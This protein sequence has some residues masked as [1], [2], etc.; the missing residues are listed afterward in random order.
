MGRDKITRREMLQI[1]GIAVAVGGV[2][3][4]LSSASTKN[5]VVRGRSKEE[6]PFRISLNTATI[7]GYELPVEQQI[8][9]CAK[10]GFDGIELWISD[11]KNYIKQGGTPEALSRQ[12]KQQGLLLENMITFSTWMA[13]DPERR[14]EGVR[15]MREDM[16]LT[17]RLGASWIAAPVQGIAAVE[18]EKLSEY[19]G[20]YQ[21]ILEAGDEVGVTPLIEPWGSGALS[22]LSDAA[23]I[24]I[25]TGHSKASMLLDFY[26]LYRGGNSFDSLWLINGSSLPL[27]HINDYPGSIVREELKDADRIFPGDGICPFDKLLPLLFQTGFRGALSIELFNRTYWESMDVEELLKKSFSSISAVIDNSLLVEG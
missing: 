2:A 1:S 7:R 6:R 3:G 13:D 15:S 23:A 21:T 12:I 5:D 22:Q 9:L 27:I 17:V 8:D 25:E 4:L 18:R 10:A 14:A 16:E 19:S 11:V 24:T 26:H 20:R